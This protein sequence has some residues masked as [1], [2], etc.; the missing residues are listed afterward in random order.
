V[1]GFTSKGVSVPLPFELPRETQSSLILKRGELDE[2]RVSRVC[3]RGLEWMAFQRWELDPG[4]GW[5]HTNTVALHPDEVA[6]VMA[7]LAPSA[8]AMARRRQGGRRKTSL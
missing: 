5:N 1:N 2:I 7:T 8:M 6:A 4:H 3:Y